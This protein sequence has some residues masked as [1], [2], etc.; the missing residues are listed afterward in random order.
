MKNDGRYKFDDSALGV[1]WQKLLWLGGEVSIP[2]E[3]AEAIAA[4]RVDEGLYIVRVCYDSRTPNAVPKKIGVIEWFG[5]Q[6]EVWAIVA[7][8]ILADLGVPEG[9]EAINL[10][11]R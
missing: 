11:I 3:V 9:D 10:S 8:R 1:G 2:R 4:R 6:A 5:G 7:R